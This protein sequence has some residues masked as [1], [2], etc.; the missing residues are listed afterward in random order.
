MRRT[1]LCL[2]HRW[3]CSQYRG[4]VALELCA[5]EGQPRGEQRSA[6]EGLAVRWRLW[7][8]RLG[9]RDSVHWQ[10]R[11]TVI[12]V[13]D[14]GESLHTISINPAMSIRRISAVDLEPSRDRSSLAF[15]QPPRLLMMPQT[16]PKHTSTYTTQFLDLEMVS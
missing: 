4:I 16:S 8:P 6:Q 13:R 14:C 2:H 11:S 9:L 5:V 10:T 1:A 7:L 3:I 12:V 15:S